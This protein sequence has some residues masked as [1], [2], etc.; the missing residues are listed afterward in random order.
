MRYI[1]PIAEKIGS[2]RQGT[3]LIELLIATVVFSIFITLIY[4][5]LLFVTDQVTILNDRLA[6]NDRGKRI[7]DFIA[8]D[9]E[10]V[11]FI[12]GPTAKIPYCTDGIAT[13]DV[14]EHADSDPYDTFTFLTSIPV[15][16]KM[17][18]SACYNLQ[19]D[20]NGIDN[21]DYLLTTRCDK[22]ISTSQLVVD[23][24][25]SCFNDYLA[26]ATGANNSKNGM[27]LITF[28]TIAPSIVAI[29]GGNTQVYYTINSLGTDTIN[30]GQTLVQT[31]PDNSTVFAVRQYRY[32]VDGRDLWRRGWN[33]ACVDNATD[34]SDTLDES[35]GA[36]GGIDGLQFEYLSVD[37]VTGLISTASAPPDDLGTLKAIKVW[38]L[39]RAEFP[40]D[41][42]ENKNTYTFGSTGVEVNGNS[43]NYRRVLLSRVV[44]VKNIGF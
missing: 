38:L 8:D 41:K 32:D 27:S 6:L 16:L 25:A 20:C 35:N 9:L 7:M 31:I 42:Y 23:A 5:S 44:E 17:A 40:D 28:E 10:M 18:D 22:A 11:G 14:I 3:T 33:S 19:K 43:D 13:N 29:M 37:P 34:T 39:L 30:L 4:P 2:E 21:Q 24:Q 26:P 15:E 1:N 36:D 12:I